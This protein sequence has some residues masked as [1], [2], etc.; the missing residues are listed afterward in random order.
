MNKPATLLA[1]F[2]ARYVWWRAGA[3]PI[4]DAP[5]RRKFACDEM[6]PKELLVAA[7]VEGVDLSRQEDFERDVEF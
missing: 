7:P 1:D 6:S 5:P 2:A 3:G 4:P